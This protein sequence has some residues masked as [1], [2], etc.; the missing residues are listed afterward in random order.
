MTGSASDPS[1]KDQN[2]NTGNIFSDTEG[3]SSGVGPFGTN[4]LARDRCRPPCC[5]PLRPGHT[6][7]PRGFRGLHHTTPAFVT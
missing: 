4:H 2:S 3:S 7:Q 6:D 5:A 1:L